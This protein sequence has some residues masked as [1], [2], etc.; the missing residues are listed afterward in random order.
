MKKLYEIARNIYIYIYIRSK[1]E[2]G[3]HW[4]SDAVLADLRGRRSEALRRKP[5]LIDSIGEVCP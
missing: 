1:S 3:R 2:G 4:F 5:M